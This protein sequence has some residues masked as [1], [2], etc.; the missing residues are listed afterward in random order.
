MV[1]RTEREGDPS[2]GLWQRGRLEGLH[3]CIPDGV[4]YGAAIVHLDGDGRLDSPETLALPTN[5]GADSARLHQPTGQKTEEMTV[6]LFRGHYT[7]DGDRSPFVTLSQKNEP[8]RR[9]KCDNLFS[10]LFNGIE[11][12][13]IWGQKEQG[14]TSLVDQ[15]S[16]PR[17]FMKGRIIHDE[18]RVG[19]KLLKEML[20]QPGIEPLHIGTPLKQHG[21]H[22]SRPTFPGQQAGAWP[23]VATPLP[24]DLV[25]FAC[26]PH[27]AGR[28]CAQTHFHPDRLPWLP[29]GS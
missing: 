22:Q 12:R 18:D 28:R 29:P 4:E 13:G 7:R 21:R 23:R 16:G 24:G 27:E 14:V 6:Q 5:V 20:L 19:G 8:G 10:I 25:S 1:W 17:R 3:R 26:P 9:T 11:V 15:F 2:G